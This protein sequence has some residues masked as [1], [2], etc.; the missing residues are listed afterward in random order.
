MFYLRSFSFIIFFFFLAFS[1]NASSITVSG[2]VSGVWN[3][4]TVFVEDDIA[5]PI[6]DSLFITPGVKVIFRGSYSMYVRG[7]IR[8]KGE[9]GNYIEFDVID[10]TGF[11]IDSIP[12]GGWNGIQFYENNYTQDSSILLYCDFMHGKAV[13]ADSLENHGGAICMRRS[14]RIRISNCSFSNNFAGLNGGAIYIDNTPVIIEIS[15]FYEN[16]CGPTVFPWGYGGA[17]CSDYSSPIIFG[18]NFVANSSTGTGGAVAIRYRDARVTNNEFIGNNSA[19]GGAIAYL[20]YY[21]YPFTQ[22]NNLMYDNHAEFFGG[23]IAS[24]DA[25]PIFVNNTIGGNFSSYGG[26]FYVKDSLIPE[27]HNCIL[28]NNIA[29]VGPEVYLWDA[30]ASADFYYCDIEGGSSAFGGS[31]GTGYQGIYENNIDEDPLFSGSFNYQITEGSPCIDAGSPDT[32]GLQLPMFDLDGN[33]RIDP[34]SNRIDMGCYELLR[35]G[36]QESNLNEQTD[37]EIFPN[38]AGDHITILTDCTEDISGIK[39]F[40]IYGRKQIDQNGSLKGTLNIS[41]FPSGMYII[42]LE[43]NSK[44][45]GSKRFVVK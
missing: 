27:L 5:I 21:E 44:S 36:I 29:A 11:S 42:I 17:I 14:D 45:L 1:V 34:L 31:G 7:F 18:N 4:D 15:D 6:G 13:S 20:H 26:G 23:A 25:G 30:F 10:T 12:D 43:N 3:V 37:I 32:T 40:D 19:I 28:Y 39:I 9:A 22:C 38:P 16:D 35:V 8:A 24:V 2:N 41:S 33:P